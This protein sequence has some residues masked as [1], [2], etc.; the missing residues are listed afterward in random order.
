MLRMPAEWEKQEAIW[1]AWPHNKEDW[2]KKFEP[3][4]WAYAE[5]IRHITSSQLVRLIVKNAQEE[6]S[7]MNILKR[8][9]VD[10]K[11][12]DFFVIPTDRVW[13]RDSGPT[14]VYYGKEVVLLDWH[15]NAWAKYNNWRHDNEIPMRVAGYFGLPLV[16]P[17]AIIKGKN[18]RVVLE[19]G[20]IDVNGKGTLLTT[21]EC[22]LSKKQCR[23]PG[24]TRK[25]YEKVFAEYFGISKVIWLKNGITGDDTHGHVDD[26][27]RFVNSKTIV[28]VVEKNKKDPNYAPLKENLKRLKSAKDQNGKYLNIIELPMPKPVI[29]EGMRLPASYA[30]FLITNNSVLVPT[31]N[32]PNDRIALNILSKLFPKREV[33]GIYCGDFVWGL[34][35]IHCASQQEIV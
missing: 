31:F 9:G 32:D 21:E 22:L 12:I 13:L 28:T 3:I 17:H 35:T 5:I 1:L 14:F 10:F 15:F 8:V 18:T 24:L 7:A 20:A 26:L 4:P 2:P 25:G 16:Q 33:I 19:G 30:N 27:A 11:N 34:G 23:N 6:K 29:F